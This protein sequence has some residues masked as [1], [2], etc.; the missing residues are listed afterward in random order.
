MATASATAPEPTLVVDAQATPQGW[1]DGRRPGQVY[2]LGSTF[3]P[4]TDSLRAALD[5][6]LTSPVGVAVA[7]VNGRYAG[8]VSA[9]D[10]LA[11]ATVSRAAVADG[12]SVRSGDA[13]QNTE[14]GAPGSVDGGAPAVA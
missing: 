8:V 9:K 13:V 2:G 4:E 6:A 1:V 10:I 7:V 11:A 14:T 12:V 5:A 3:N